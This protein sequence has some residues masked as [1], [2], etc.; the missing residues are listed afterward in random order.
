MMRGIE[1]R[2]EEEDGGLEEEKEGLEGEEVAENGAATSTQGPAY[3]WLGSDRD[4]AY[5]ELLGNPTWV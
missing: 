1:Q 3:P 5:D 2:A 4:Y